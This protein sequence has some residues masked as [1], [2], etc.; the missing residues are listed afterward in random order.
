MP[1][2]PGFYLL[3]RTYSHFRAY[4]GSR[5]LEELVSRNLIAPRPSSLLDQIYRNGLASTTK[6]LPSAPSTGTEKDIKDNGSETNS[7]ATST[8]SSKEEAEDIIYLNKDSGSL[9]ADAFETKAMAIEIE[10]AVEQVEKALKEEQKVNS[11]TEK[12]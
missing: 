11:E 2:I 5:H 8:N 3:F 7:S 1:N 6:Q 10:R 4:Y 9:I 12:K